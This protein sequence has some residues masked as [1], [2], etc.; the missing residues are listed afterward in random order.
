MEKLEAPVR[1]HGLMPAMPYA[2]RSSVRQTARRA[3]D[4]VGKSLQAGAI[5]HEFRDGVVVSQAHEINDFLGG[6]A[7]IYDEASSCNIAAKL[8][9]DEEQSL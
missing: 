6:G 3:K 9:D 5:D 7:S 4:G 8:Y 2:Q 1:I